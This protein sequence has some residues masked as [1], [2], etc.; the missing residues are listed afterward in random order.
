M[1]DTN[2]IGATSYGWL[3][4]SWSYNAMV[5]MGETKLENKGLSLLG[6]MNNIISS[7]FAI[8]ISKP[9]KLIEGDNL[10]IGLSQPLRIESGNSSIMIPQLYDHSKD[11]TYNKISFSLEPSGRQLDLNI[12]YSV[13]ED[14]NLHYGVL[15]GA[16]Q[17]YGHI[18][19]DHITHSAMSFIKYSF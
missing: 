12:G 15:F 4:N 5:T 10:E 11:L 18:K 7:S 9:M 8:D 3:N 13:K 2:F 16:S 1:A 14:S 17:D 19:S 6:D